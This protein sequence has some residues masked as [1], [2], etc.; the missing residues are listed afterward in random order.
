MN[1]SLATNGTSTS[2]SEV[3]CS[4]V[5]GVAVKRKAG[6]PRKDK[7]A[8]KGSDKNQNSHLATNGQAVVASG[9][10]SLSQTEILRTTENSDGRVLESAKSENNAAPR[11]T[12][13]RVRTPRKDIHVYEDEDETE[14]KRERKGSKRKQSEN[15]A[16]A[17]NKNAPKKRGR[18]PKS[19]SAENV[20]DDSVKDSNCIKTPG[21]KGGKKRKCDTAIGNADAVVNDLDKGRGKDGHRDANGDNDNVDDENDDVCEDNAE[22][23]IDNE[24]GDNEIDEDDD[25][26]DDD[27]KD[28]NDDDDEWSDSP[29]SSSKKKTSQ[30]VKKAGTD[31]SLLIHLLLAILN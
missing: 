29:K 1:E 23:D 14:K 10:V 25:D 30:P 5:T 12:S 4:Q 7:S 22:N 24:D 31:Y 16:G 26:D 3:N 21:K 6:R 11:R 19:A 2:K 15:D 20:I 13:T 18:K 27:D 28:D 9:T 8:I 17:S